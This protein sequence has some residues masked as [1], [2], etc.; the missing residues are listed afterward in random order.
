MGGLTYSVQ[1]FSNN[2]EPEELTARLDKWIASEDVARVTDSYIDTK[3]K[4]KCGR[5]AKRTSRRR[6][7]MYLVVEHGKSLVD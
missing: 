4:G 2:I 7:L 3:R 1:G 6:E 5:T